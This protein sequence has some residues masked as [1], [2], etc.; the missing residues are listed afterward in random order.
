LLRNLLD[1]LPGVLRNLLDDLP[2]V[3]RNLLDDRART[4]SSAQRRCNVA[5]PTV[6][7]AVT[8]PDGSTDIWSTT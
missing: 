6:V 2:G 1:D 7:I 5:T 3:L 8:T 4:C